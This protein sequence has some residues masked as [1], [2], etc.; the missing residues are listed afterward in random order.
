MVIAYLL[1]R[2][3]VP[4]PNWYS[5]STLPAFRFSTAGL[6]REAFWG[7][8]AMKPTQP[9]MRENFIQ[10]ANILGTVENCSAQ[11]LLA[12]S[13]G[14]RVVFQ[15]AQFLAQNRF[16]QIVL[17]APD[18][19]AGTIENQMSRFVGRGERNTLYSST[20]DL[21]LSLSRW[22]HG[23]VRGGQV[24]TSNF[25]SIDAS[26]INF[27]QFGHSYFHDQRPLLSDLFL[28]LEHGLPPSER[29]LI[30]QALDGV[31]WAF[32]P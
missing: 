27:S 13:M 18:E 30:C 32:Q 4:W 17:A 5:I 12:H 7:T 3:R 19:D 29:P 6:P 1:R 11:H 23:A 20:K 26:A 21:A 31:T 16:G 24:G 9:E 22:V 10:F 25:D 8:R 14:N 28:V 15:G 2:P